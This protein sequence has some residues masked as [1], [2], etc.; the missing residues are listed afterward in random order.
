MLN[1]TG[2]KTVSGI[3]R[4]ILLVDE[5]NSTAISCMVANTGVDAVDGKKIVKA[6][7][8]LNGDFEDR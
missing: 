1:Q 4:K 3:T 6:G 5:K 2:F 7:T 8:P